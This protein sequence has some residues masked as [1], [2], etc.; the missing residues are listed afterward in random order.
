MKTLPASAPRAALYARIST[1][2]KGQNLENQLGELRNYAERM[3]WII[4]RQYL[5]TETGARNDRPE[6]DKMMKAAARREFDL[7]AVFDLSRLTRTGP[8]GAFEL[9]GRLMKSGVRF[10]SMTEEHFRTAGPAGELFIAIAAYI[11]RAERETLQHRIRAGLDRARKSGKAIG[12]PSSVIDRDRLRKLQGEG[13]SIREIA[14]KLK[15][16]PSTIARKMKPEE[17]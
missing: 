2:D 9:I 13:L 11:A 12:R 5:D 1:R 16:S 14:A 15:T 17:K 8:A 10:W 4:E 3:E 7:V 6:L